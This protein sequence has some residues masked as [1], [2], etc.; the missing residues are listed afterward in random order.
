M[1]LLNDY[2]KI[3]KEIYKFFNYTEE[4]RVYPFDDGRNYFWFVD[5]NTVHFADSME[6]LETEEGNCYSREIVRNGVYRGAGFTMIAVNTQCD[7]NQFLQIFDNSKLAQTLP[8]L[9]E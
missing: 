5:G 6:E 7:W 4:W 9:L 1:K 8:R 3:Q 2:N